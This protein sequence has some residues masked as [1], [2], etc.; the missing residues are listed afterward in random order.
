MPYR[1]REEGFTLIEL[2]I[3]VAI[4]GILASMLIPNLLDALQKT[5]QKRS[6]ADARIVGTAMMSWI[7]DRSQAMAAGAA[8]TDVDMAD[9]PTITVDDLTAQ[10]V[11]QYLQNVPVHDAWKNEFDFRLDIDGDDETIMAVRSRGADNVFDA[12]VYTP[13]A[14]DPT[15]YAQDIVWV[16][17]FY[18]RW[19]QKL[20]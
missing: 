18:V 4:I 12:D 14:F 15:D 16:D 1:N 10:L 9:Y 7:T 20:N 17:G 11:P 6:M 2:L 8:L 13:S 3:V 19:P 5:K